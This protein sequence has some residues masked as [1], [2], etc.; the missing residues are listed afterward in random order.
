MS[1]EGDRVASLSS[2]DA[3]LFLELPCDIRKEI[4]YHLNGSF[5]HLEPSSIS[6]LYDINSIGLVQ[7]KKQKTEHERQ[8]I[9]KLYTI[10]APFVDIFEY[11]PDILLEW[12]KYSLWLRYDA[13]VLDCLRLNHAY[14]GF[15][16]GPMDW[17]Y[18][19]T[20]LSL[21]Y[22][23]KNGLLQV[24]YSKKEFN[25]WII[26]PESIGEYD[27]DPTYLKFSMEYLKPSYISKCL[28]I[29]E[30]KKMLNN[31]YQVE[32]EDINENN[33]A[34][35]P[36]QLDDSN[37]IINDTVD[38]TSDSSI[39]VDSSV[40]ED[41]DDS[42]SH[43]TKNRKRKRAGSPEIALKLNDNSVIEIVAQLKKMKNIKKIGIRGDILFDNLINSHGIRDR[44]DTTINYLV[45]RRI[46]EIDIVQVSDFTKYGF[47]DYSKW[48]NLQ[49]LSLINI[50]YCDM[51]MMVLP[52]YCQSLIFKNI[53]KLRWFNISDSVVNIEIN[54]D[55]LSNVC[56]LN[57]NDTCN[58][59]NCNHLKIYKFKESTIKSRLYLNKLWKIFGSLNYIRLE[60]I[61]EIIGAQIIVPNNL[62]VNHRILL[63]SCK[64]L[65]KVI[66]L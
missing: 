26:E 30:K 27:P 18:L 42:S 61:S 65:K 7:N 11:N 6:D 37:T 50:G 34:R 41:N 23:N 63:F 48:D 5:T 4:Y 44:R 62:Y 12:L 17:I 60:N 8:L 53:G 25:Q 1:F 58:G 20:R 28:E 32:F 3:S 59:V 49:K 57:D 64:N 54:N 36:S 14:E 21:G 35:I 2:M 38:I 16:I 13:I 45:K 66:C 52:K 56:I 39:L 9:T 29:F 55:K 24:W 47:S 33:L 51:N 31:I 10:F 40:A 46:Q 43:E 15:L 19:D 22:F